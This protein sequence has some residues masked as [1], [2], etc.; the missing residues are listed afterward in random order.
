MVCISVPFS[1]RLDFSE[2][3]RFE[4]LSA[5][6]TPDNCLKARIV[7]LILVTSNKNS[8]LCQSSVL[9]T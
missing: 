5:R 4:Y 1:A 7:Q 6:F 9:K 3:P 2:F 8:Y